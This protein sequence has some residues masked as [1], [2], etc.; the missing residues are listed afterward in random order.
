MGYD[1]YNVAATT[2]AV[3]NRFVTS[4]NMSLTPYTIANASP[5]WAG[6]C[7]VTIAHTTVA[8]ADTLGTI[9]IVGTDLFG[10]AQSEVLTPV[11][12]STVTS[13]KIFRTVTSATSVGW[14]AVSTADT[15]VI[16]CAAGSIVA[17]GGGIAKQFI[18]NVTAAAT[19]VLSD[20]GGVINTY[21]A[22]IPVGTYDL[23]ISWS[24]YLSIATTSTNDVTVISTTGTPLNYAMS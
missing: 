22:S 7:F 13:K 10:L 21:P 6:G 2:A 19:V 17:Q 4:T 8:G 14:V 1:A 5:V 20:G 24:G 15:I 16:G 12:A 23:D 9:T 11:A 18:V 3:T